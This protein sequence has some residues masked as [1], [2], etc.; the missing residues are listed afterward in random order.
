MG[1][2]QDDIFFHPSSS[3]Q[4]WLSIL[5]IIRSSKGIRWSRLMFLKIRSSSSHNVSYP[6]TIQSSSAVYSSLVPTTSILESRIKGIR[7]RVRSRRWATSFI[8]QPTYSLHPL[9]SSLFPSL[10]VPDSQQPQSQLSIPEMYAV[11]KFG[12]NKSFAPR[13]TPH[14]A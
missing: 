12:L 14:Y 7:G 4:P 6:I 11:V 1:V 3:Q 2:S 9:Q 8:Q 10:L 13:Y 5:E